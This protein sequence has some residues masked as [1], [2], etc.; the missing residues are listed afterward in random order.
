MVNLEE[1]FDAIVDGTMVKEAKPDPEVFLRAASMLKLPP[2]QCIVFED[3][4]AGVEA[5]HNGG[6]R[7]IG[8]GKEDVLSNADVVLPVLSGL[9]WIHM[10]EMIS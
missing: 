6:M 4:P 1:R 5:A 9:R 3:A 7:C 2:E 8:I 10:L